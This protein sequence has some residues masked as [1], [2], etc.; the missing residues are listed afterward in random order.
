MTNEEHL[1]IIQDIAQ[2]LTDQ[3]KVTELLNSL[4]TDYVETLASS[5]TLLTDNEKFKTDNESLR[6]ANMKL[7]L[8]IG[9]KPATP[10]N[11]V[12]PAEVT[13]TEPELATFDKLFNEKGELI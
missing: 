3:A 8:Q 10:V 1:Q 5:T 11:T 9:E 6:S 12:T 13:Q 7:F 2:N 4:S